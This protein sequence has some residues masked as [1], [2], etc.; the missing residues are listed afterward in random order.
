MKTVLWW[1]RSDRNYSRNRILKGAFEELGWHIDYFHPKSS[2]LG[3]FESYFRKLRQPDLI[4][5]PCFRHTDISSAAARAS[6]WNVPLII[7]PLISAYEKE[8]FE[9]KK[10]PPDSARG[11]RRKRWETELFSTADVVIADTPAH[12]AFY[13]NEL[14]VP[15]ERLCI[16]Y[17]GA[18]ESVFRPMPQQPSNACFEVFFYGSFLQLQGVEVII[19]AARMTRDLAIRWTLLGE[20]P[21]RNETMRYAEGLGNVRFEPWIDYDRLPQ[22]IARANVVLGIFGTTPKADWVI[23]N[24]VFQTMAV[25]RPLITRRAAAYR[26][27]VEGSDVIGWV[28]PGNPEALAMIVKKWFRNPFELSNRGHETRILYDRFFG[29]T[30]IVQML[31]AALKKALEGPI[32]VYGR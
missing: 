9:R 21:L 26:S 5:V 6:K 30:R 22:R 7:D 31:D 11:E 8:V 2:R 20:G 27:S 18:E 1:G 16:L 14:S 19:A 15:P 13:E 28:P 3:R 10:Y 17:V 4:W 32:I 25:G 12:A 29:R 23:P 24:K